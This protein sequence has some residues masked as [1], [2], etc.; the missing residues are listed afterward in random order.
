MMKYSQQTDYSQ[1][2]K[3]IQAKILIEFFFYLTDINNQALKI[4]SLLNFTT[5]VKIPGNY[6]LYLHI[7]V[8]SL[9]VIINQI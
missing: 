9:L 2:Q 7:L 3:F 6:F 4:V 8:K 5:K 1:I